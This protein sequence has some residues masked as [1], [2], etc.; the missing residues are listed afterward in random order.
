MPL[1]AWPGDVV[2][3]VYEKRCADI[4]KDE[5]YTP[6]DLADTPMIPTPKAMRGLTMGYPLDLSFGGRS[7][8]VRSRDHLG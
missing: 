3:D 8:E 6:L 7:I 1:R 2:M 4:F 5:I